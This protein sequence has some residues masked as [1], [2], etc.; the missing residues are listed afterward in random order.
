MGVANWILLLFTH[1]NDF[2]Y[3]LQFSIYHE[4]K[5][6]ITSMKEH[7]T[8]GWD[9]E[10][11][12]R[13][14]HFLDLTSRSFSA[15]IKELEGDL[16]RTICIFYLVL[17]GLDTI[18]DDMTIPDE[19]KQP[20]LR[21]FHKHTVTPGWRFTGCGPNEKDRQLLIEYD[22]VVGEVNLLAPHYRDVIINICEKM[23]TGMADYAHA[24]YVGGGT[25]YLLTIAEYDLYCHYVAGLVG[26]GLS[27]IFGVSGKEV[28]WIGDQLELS[29]SM[30]L[31]LQKTNIIRD[32]REDVEER[33]FFW[34]KEI[35]GSKLY[36]FNEMREMYEAIDAD[37]GRGTSEK[38]RKAMYAQSA[39]IL[40]ALRHATDALDYLKILKNQSVFNFC[41]IPAT[42]AIATL[43]LCHMNP[44]MFLRN[45]KIRKAEAAKLIMRSTNPRDVGLIFCEYAR[46]IH[47]KTLVSDPSFLKI[48]V[49]CGK[50]EQWLEHQYP[51]FVQLSDGRQTLNTYDPRALIVQLETERDLELTKKKRVEEIRARI[52]ANGSSNGTLDTTATQTDGGMWEA[53]LYMGGALLLVTLFCGAGIWLMLKWADSPVVGS[54]SHTARVEL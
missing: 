25:V 49:A 1:P 10:S 26:E 35:W 3:L 17:R 47:A 32:Y 44:E 20:I 16:A 29:N 37:G 27:G 11:M 51:S 23:Q 34:P 24:A 19:V 46:K 15:V 41:A 14:W 54:S 33:R 40:D 4:Q 13:C 21:S 52:S 5:R 30:G 12:R 9:R 28:P 39:M 6:D 22:T 53:V 2:R 38:G 36:G 45:I 50:I 43:E 18:E 8:S 48:S 42:M 31:L 7:P